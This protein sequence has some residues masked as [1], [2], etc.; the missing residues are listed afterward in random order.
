MGVE[1]GESYRRAGVDIDAASRAK[2]RIRELVGATQGP[3]VLGGIGGFGGLYA[4][5]GGAD[6]VL[7]ASADSVGTKLKLAIALDRHDTIGEDIVNHCVDD[8]L[9]CGARPLF[10]L[11][12]L[13]MSRVLPEQVEQIVAGMAR[14][15]AVNGLALIGGETAELPGLYAPGDYDVAGFIVGAVERGRILDG[16]AVR[17]GDILLGL[18][19][20]GL[21]TNGYSLARRVLGLS[22]DPAAD[23]AIL[24][25]EAPA[26][27][28]SW[29]EALMAVH[30]SYLPTVWPLLEAGLVRSIAHITGGGLIDNVPRALPAGLAA[31]FQEGSWSVPPIFTALQARGSIAPDEMYRVFNMGLGLVLVC[32]PA[33]VR[34]IQQRA[35]EAIVVGEV[36]AS[37][38]D[39]PRVLIET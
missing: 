32:A 28:G 24:E 36:A 3:E 30:R 7:V 31:H 25:A 29:A 37:V 23:R 4:F 14:A 17:A 19:S 5:A 34:A 10:F 1:V 15:C 38:T 27:G 20:S 21:H 26:V 12:Y 39:R 6:S 22:G 8:I 16:A 13:G 33:A 35:P 2:A 9:A 18:P 11:D